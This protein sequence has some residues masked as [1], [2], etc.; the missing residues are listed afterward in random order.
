MVM[1]SP[2]QLK[3]ILLSAER[4]EHVASHSLKATLSAQMKLW[5]SDLSVSELLGYHAIGV[6][7][8]EAEGEQEDLGFPRRCL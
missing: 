7:E 8:H 3:F 1:P 6:S 4:S 2:A 5:G